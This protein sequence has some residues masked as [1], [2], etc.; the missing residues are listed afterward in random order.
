[1]LNN[2]RKRQFYFHIMK[3]FK[4]NDFLILK[5]EE[6][7]TNIYVNGV[8]FEQCKYLMLNIPVE[9]TE[10]F[11]EIDSIDEAADL[12]G[13]SEEGQEGVE[14]DIDPETEFWGHCS[15][16][17]AWYEHD[18][19]T[20]LLHSNISFPLLKKLVMVGDLLAQKLFKKELEKRLES[21]YPPVI[22]YII[23]EKFL[24]ILDEDELVKHLESEYLP[25]VDHIEDLLYE[26]IYQERENGFPKILK[27]NEKLSWK[28]KFKILSQ[29]ISSDLLEKNFDTYLNFIKDLP[30]IYKYRAFYDLFR[31]SKTETIILMLKDTR[32][33]SQ[34][35]SLLENIKERRE[36]WQAI[37]I[38]QCV[39]HR[40]EDPFFKILKVAKKEG[41]IKDYISTLLET[42]EVLYYN[43][44]RAFHKIMKAIKSLDLLDNYYQQTEF[45]FL[46][47][48]NLFDFDTSTLNI[49][50]NWYLKDK[51]QEFYYFINAIKDTKLMVKY[52]PQV[53]AIFFSLMNNVY[54]LCDCDGILYASEIDEEFDH[55]SYACDE[56]HQEEANDFLY[57]T[58]KG[59]RLEN[60]SR[61]KDWSKRY[62]E[63]KDYERKHHY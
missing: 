54:K 5:L 52:Y 46:D 45:I 4:V 10:K 18:Y 30:D 57:E 8:L 31:K 58:V 59:T 20:R 14:Y 49:S 3:E 56:Y 43:K 6:G 21:G 42:H 15:N 13:W 55:H 24:K 1:M 29:A 11:D 34:E 36:I 2:V 53:K 40:H 23:N 35:R 33:N 27:T 63:N 26:N 38:R 44:Y 62:Q 7:K 32:F 9:E 17:Q 51:Y 16:L 48:L 47:L 61:Y 60:E 39:S 25:L 19:D 28:G 50:L 41:W 22:E 12:L 37:K